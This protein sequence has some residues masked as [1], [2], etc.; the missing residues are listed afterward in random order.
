MRKLCTIWVSMVLFL[1]ACSD[2]TEIDP[3]GKNIL[4]TVE[5]LNLL[6]N[7][8]YSLYGGNYVMNLT[9]DVYPQMTNIP[10]LLS[11]SPRTLKSIYVAWDESADRVSLTNSDDIYTTLYEICGQVA[12]PV[13]QNIDDAEG[14][15]MKAEQL[16][17]EA[18]VLRGWCHYLLVNIYAKAFN[19]ETAAEDSGIVY[20]LE[21]D[22]MEEPNEQLTVA[23]VYEHVLSDINE[24][25]A[26]GSL[27]TVPSDMRIGLP[28]AYAARAK[29]L[30]SMRDY[31]GAFAAADSCLMLSNV[32][33][34]Y[35]DLIVPDAMYM[36]GQDEFTRPNLEMEE[37]LFYTPQMFFYEA[38]TPE[39]WDTFEEGHVFKEYV[40]TDV[41]AFGSNANGIASY[42]ALED[43]HYLV[44]LN[45]YYNPLGLTTVDMYLT[46]AECFIR[47]GE[48][49]AAMELLNQIREKRIIRDRY[50]ERT[51]STT[52]E[53]FALMKSISRTENFATLKNFINL[54]RWNTEETYRETLHKTI[55]WTGYI[56]DGQQNVTGTERREYTA[57]L[58][59]DSPLWILPFPLNATAFN[60]NLKQ[61]CLAED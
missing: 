60:P 19:P 48:I 21:T 22:V 35:N 56:L 50:V 20:A 53:A 24:A 31:E 6:L 45:V 12:N 42:G 30:M 18:L 52:E 7:Y 29:V 37:E 44:C 49:E 25:I 13:L 39:L 32:I 46:K 41:K 43:L 26:L 57:E 9:G 54:K 47:N 58:T 51:A 8:E 55:G 38:V 23:E 10:N 34:D 2:F 40:L 17:A 59:P 11:E 28:F 3:K 15:R 14:D 61:N 33:D 27:P 16:K 36:S 5:D 1:G 4:K